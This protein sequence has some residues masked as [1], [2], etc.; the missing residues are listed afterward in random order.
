MPTITNY[1]FSTTAITHFIGDE[2]TSNYLWL[3][4]AQNTDGDCLLQKVIAT[5]PFQVVYE[6]EIATNEIT[7]LRISGT[8]IYVALDDASLIGQ[9]YSLTNPLTTSTNYSLPVGINESPIDVAVIGSYVYFLTPGAITGE[10]AKIVKIGL[11]GTYHSTIDLT[12]VTN[13]TSFVNSD[14]S[15]LWLVTGTSPL[16]LVRIYD[17]STTPQFTVL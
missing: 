14:A 11:T 4:F 3:G 2:S 16:H 6:I 9:R 1:N 15:E 7:K 12:P 13:A 8:Y 5:N 17:L 10:N